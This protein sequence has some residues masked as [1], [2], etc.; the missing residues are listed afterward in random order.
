MA[1][2][3]WSPERR[4]RHSNAIKRSLAAPEIRR[5]KSEA[6]KR[7]WADPVVRERR[8]NGLKR[9]LADP[10][11][12]R[13]RSESTKRFYAD[14]VVRRRAGDRMRNLLAD[15][16]IRR[17][18]SEGLKRMLAD[19]VKRQRHCDALRHALADPEVRRRQTEGIKRS[20]VNAD[21]RRK[22]T[23]ERNKKVWAERKA[24]LAAAEI[25]LASAW[26]PTDW[27]KRPFEWRT[28]GTELLSRAGYMSN[29]ELA[30]RLD[31]SR[32]ITCPYDKTW[33]AAIGRKECSMFI[34]RIRR[35]VH[36]PGK[37]ASTKAA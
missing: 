3:H 32:I 27:G 15:P 19:P 23:S 18:M 1:K 12:R 9:S 14:P 33:C 16:T 6:S 5:R 30:T 34:R 20:W 31:S 11:V 35:W 24:T 2:R 17:R 25:N 26:R 37:I 10:A 22:Q 8:I 7:S 21:A 13:R 28:I 29:R 4:K 36:R